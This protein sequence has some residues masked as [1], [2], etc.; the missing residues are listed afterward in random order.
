MSFLESYKNQSGNTFSSF[1]DFHMK[2]HDNTDATIL[3]L[4]ND[5]RLVTKKN[6]V[7]PIKK[8]VEM[9]LI[10]SGCF[11]F[12]ESNRIKLLNHYI[13]DIRREKPGSKIKLLNKEETMPLNAKRYNRKM[14]LA[15]EKFFMGTYIS[16]HPLDPFPYTDLEQCNDNEQVK[17]AGIVSSA[18][19]KKT[20]RNSDF[21]NIRMKAKDD[22]ERTV[23]VF[24]ETLSK[25]LYKDLKK[26]QIIVVQGAYSKQYNNI[27]AKSVK[28]QIPKK[29]ILAMEEF[30]DNNQAHDNQPKQPQMVVEHPGYADIWP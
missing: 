23:N 17:I 22:I 24:N 6:S 30:T 27:N 18:T 5:I 3:K 11:D 15:L 28:I 26:N 10:L 7:N 21:L 1:D 8:D 9:A 2:I 25:S 14:K 12:A 13:M 29:Q 20:K 16:E 19:M 4:I